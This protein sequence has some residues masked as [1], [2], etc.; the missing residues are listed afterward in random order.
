[1]ETTIISKLKEF[2]FT[3]NESKTYIALLKLN[4]ATGYEVSQRSGVPRSAVYNI[5]R[6]LELGGIVSAQGENPA[7]YVPVP[8][9]QLTNKLTS[10]FDHNIRE[11][12]ESL[13]QVDQKPVDENTWNIK[14]YKAMIEQARHMIDSAEKS[15]FCSLWSRE[16]NEL[17]SQFKGA[18]ER[19]VDIINFSFTKIRKPVSEIFSYDVDEDELREIWTRQIVLVVDRKLVLLGGADKNIENRSIW[20]DNPSILTI[21]INYIILD[22]TL[23]SHRNGVDVAKQTERMTC[24]HT[25]RLAKLL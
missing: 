14:G 19:G 25:E 11:L 22:L 23:F 13:N 9:D 3:Q 16:Y 18:S 20:T 1:M 17:E 4:P 6:K 8:P 5:L 21:A 10:Q 15:I 24:P 7:S 2:G 12:R